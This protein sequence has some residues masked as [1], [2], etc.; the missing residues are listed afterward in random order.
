MKI[1]YLDCIFFGGGGGVGGR[2]STRWVGV[3]VIAEKTKIYSYT[4]AAKYP[5]STG[6]FLRPDKFKW[7]YSRISLIWYPQN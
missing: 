3:Q 2:V 5:C 7:L 1:F 6:Y 4:H